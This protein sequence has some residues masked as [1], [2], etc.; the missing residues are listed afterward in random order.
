MSDETSGTTD[1]GDAE[2][3]ELEGVD[4]TPEVK[5][6][7][8]YPDGVPSLDWKKDELFAYTEQND[9][10]V[11]SD[12]TKAEL[13]TAIAA[14]R[15][16]KPDPDKYT[17]E[18]VTIPPGARGPLVAKYRKALGMGDGYRFDRAMSNRVR[19]FQRA[20]GL[21]VTGALDEATRRRLGTRLR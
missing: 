1:M 16:N 19:R 18:S 5:E 7:P 12:S 11:S 17:D 10:E 13:L 20:M 8:S 15:I 14:E 3:V 9:I 2:T 4:E 6:W 21:S